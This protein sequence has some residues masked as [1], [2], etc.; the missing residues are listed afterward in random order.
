MQKTTW[1]GILISVIFLFL[2][3]R[4]FNYNEFATAMQNVRY[5][6][7]APAVIVYLF[8]FVLRGMRWG[9][10]LD[11]VGNV[12]FSSCFSI[13]FI[14][15]MA[16]ALLP[17]RLGEFVRAYVMGKKEN[18]S[19]IASLSSII[20]ERVFD[21]IIIVFF[22][23]ILVLIYPFPDWIRNLGNITSIIFIGGLIFLYSLVNQKKRVLEFIEKCLS[24]LSND[25]RLKINSFLD[26]FILGLE[27]LKNKYQSITVFVLSILVWFIEIIV[28]YLLL[29]ALNIHIQTLFYAAALT[30][31]VVNFAIMIPSSPGNIG[32]FHYFCIL[33]LSIFGVS[34]N[35]AMA[36]SIVMFA[37][38]YISVVVPGMFFMWKMGFSINKLKS[39]AKGDLNE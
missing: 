26:R 1:I 15:F 19:K 5:Y 38:M 2:A 18:I 24:F 37:L 11:S 3:F 8:S 10:L 17:M 9:L 30:M 28:Y 14:G 4:N 27:M 21:G 16:N 22:L 31:I 29:L 39:S 20:L 35:T 13:V 36:Y 12:P 7:I 25:F 32:T 6:Y 34:K 33:A 23:I